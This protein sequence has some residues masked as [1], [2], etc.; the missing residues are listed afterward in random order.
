MITLNLR[1]HQKDSLSLVNTDLSIRLISKLCLEP[2][3]PSAHGKCILFWMSGW[4]TGSWVSK[5]V[6]S[7]YFNYTFINF[8]IEHVF[9]YI[10]YMYYYYYLCTTYIPRYNMEQFIVI[11]DECISVIQIAFLIGWN[12]YNISSDDCFYPTGDS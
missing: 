11:S 12:F 5:P 7:N 10:V 6:P 2:Q 1:D 8:L 4:K 9:P 3:Y